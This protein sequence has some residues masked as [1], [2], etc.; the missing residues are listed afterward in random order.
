MLDEQDL[1]LNGVRFGKLNVWGILSPSLCAC[2]A[3]DRLPVC[4][5]RIGGRI[6]FSF[7]N[8]DDARD[9][10]FLTANIDL[11]VLSPNE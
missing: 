10:D 3:T 11:D 7:E 4:A 9:L 5:K 8:W 6:S 1:L 2:V